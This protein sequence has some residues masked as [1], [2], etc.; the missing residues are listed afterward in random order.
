MNRSGTSVYDSLAVN[1]GVAY[2]LAINIGG[3]LNY[4]I[5]IS[6]P[7]DSR[8]ENPARTLKTGRPCDSSTTLIDS[9][10]IQKKDLQ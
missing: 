10:I 2:T 1:S 6:T 5:E 9:S 4:P 3:V 8:E 7:P